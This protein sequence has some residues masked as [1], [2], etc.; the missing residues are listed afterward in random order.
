M[1]FSLFCI[2]KS[3]FGG[4]GTSFKEIALEYVSLCD[5]LPYTCGGLNALRFK[6]N[7]SLCEDW[8]FKEM[9]NLVDG[10]FMVMKLLLFCHNGCRDSAGWNVSGFHCSSNLF[11]WSELDTL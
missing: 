2:S 7:S 8:S 1:F 10:S 11:C 6:L 9:G 5:L 3:G 4:R